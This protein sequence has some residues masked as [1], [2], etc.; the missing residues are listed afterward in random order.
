MKRCL[1][2]AMTLLSIGA[3][4]ARADGNHAQRWFDRLD[5]NKDGVISRDEVNAHRAERFAKIDADGDGMISPAE[6]NARAEAHFTRA[7]TDGNGE[8]T[9]DEFAA[10]AEQWR[11]KHDQSQ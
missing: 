4:S 1:I 10:A 9:K 2:L 11:K 5:T 6:Y 7:D 3:S 8:I